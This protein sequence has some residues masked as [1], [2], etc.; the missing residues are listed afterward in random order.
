MRR[1]AAFDNNWVREKDVMPWINVAAN[2]ASTSRPNNCGECLGITSSSRSLL[3][4]GRA[5]L[6]TRFTTINKNPTDKI[7]RRG[8][9]NSQTIGI[10]A[11]S[12]CT[13]GGLGSSLTEAINLPFGLRSQLFRF[14][15]TALS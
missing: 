15:I 1:C 14:I 8:R 7:P 13:F 10:T 5:K 12:L 2:T 4:Y 9:A 11:R 6:Q 3:E